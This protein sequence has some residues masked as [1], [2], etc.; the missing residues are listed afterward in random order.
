M[1]TTLSRIIKYGLLG[2]WRNGWLSTATIAVMI[3]AL[4]VFEGL[5][6]FNVVTKTAMESLKEKIDISVYFKTDASEDEILN[7]KKS[8][9]SMTEVKGVEYISRDKALEIFKARH[10]GD[11]TI[12]AALGELKENPLAAS[13]NIKAYNPQ[14]YAVIDAYLKTESFKPLIDKISYAQNAMVIER[15]VKII[16]TVKRLG[17]FLTIMF[18]SI[19][20]LI[21]FNTIR[22]AI[23][24]NREEISIMRLV[25]ASNFFTRGPYLVEGIIYGLIAGFLS[26]GVFVPVIYFI[27]PYIK[28]FIPEMNL[29]VY[30]Y[31]N[32]LILIG[33]QILFGVILGVISSSIAIRKYLN[34]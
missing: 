5:I 13:L 22:L 28:T 18:S 19:A 1:F 24:S 21:T 27:A 20:V 32:S 2:F 15:L 25:G 4:M 30:L 6:V 16:D 7:I 11:E 26:F 23:Y 29:W 9:S 34:I 17:L 3:L 10:E 8:L 14:D 31:S 33:Y 12:V